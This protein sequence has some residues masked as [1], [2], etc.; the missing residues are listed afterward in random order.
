MLKP[1]L[2][3]AWYFDLPK[4]TPEDLAKICETYM[5]PGEELT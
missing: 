1:E 5:P 4:D 2:A 3:L